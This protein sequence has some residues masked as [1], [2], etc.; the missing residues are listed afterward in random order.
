VRR[1][2]W[3]VLTGSAGATAVHS[4]F[5]GAWGL[6]LI[7]GTFAVACSVRADRLDRRAGAE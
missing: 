3:L 6:A 1:D 7:E 4:V 5:E 2:L